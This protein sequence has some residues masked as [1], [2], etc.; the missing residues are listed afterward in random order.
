MKAGIV[1]LPNV[2]KSTLFKALTKKA[3]DI[4]NYPF[5]TIEPNVGVVEVP[6]ARLWKLSELSKS[7]K[8]IP[9][10]FEF[11]DIAGLVKGAS[12]GEGLGNK[13][14][15]NIREVDAIVQVVRVFENGNII[16]VH[17]RV[18]PKEDIDIVNTELVLADLET[19]IKRKEK[20]VKDVRA[21]VKGAEQ[22]RTWLEE[23]EAVLQTGGL[24]NAV[25]LSG[26]PEEAK[27]FLRGLQLLTAKPFLYVY[28]MSD[29]DAALSPELSALPHVR[30]DIKLEEELS[31]MTEA[32]ADELGVKS[33]LGDLIVEAYSLLGLETFFTT[34][35]DETRAWTIKA[36][37]T[38]PQA[39][40]AIHGDFEERFIRAEVIFWEDLLAVGSWS[41]GRDKGTLRLEGKEYVVRDGDVIVFKI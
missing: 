11:V 35:E 9:A 14:L 26:D 23:I 37:S 36:G 2:G 17:N 5:C 3:V 22:E 41:A 12:E 6:D 34:G 39:G 15:A 28:N 33:R 20:T 40:A 21:R 29:T 19:V 1:G 38:A 24:A 4:Q 30:L 10:V 16:H 8:T 27:R 25:A 7:K 13:F 31:E 18:D 32:D